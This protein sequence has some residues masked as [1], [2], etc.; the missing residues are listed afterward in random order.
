MKPALLPPPMERRAFTLVELLL[1]IGLLGVASSVSVPLY[2]TYQARN[3]LNTA[4]EQTIQ[5]LARAKLLSQSA[6][7]DSSWGFFVPAGILYK[8]ESYKARDVVVDEVYPMPSTV[9]VSG[10]ILEVAYSKLDGRPSATGSIILTAVDGEQRTIIITVAVETEGVATNA[11]DTIAVCC[12]GPE[13]KTIV[14]SAWP[15]YESQGCTLGACPIPS[16]SSASSAVSSAQASSAAVSSQASSGTSASSVS[17]GGGGGGSSSSLPPGYFLI[18]HKP[19][20]YAEQTMTVNQSAWNNGHRKH[21]DTIGACVSTP[22]VD[23]CPVR[24]LIQE[25]GTVL[26]TASLSVVA[27]ALASEI[28]YGTGGPSINVTVTFTKKKNKSWSSLFDGD[29]IEAG[30]TDT[31]S[32]VGVSSQVALK[33]RGYFKKSGWLTFDETAV[34]NDGSDHT[35]LLRRGDPL[36]QYLPYGEQALL[37]EI[38]G[39]YLDANGRLTIAPHM[40]VVLAELSTITYP[41]SSSQDFQDAVLLLEFNG[42]PSC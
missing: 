18:C 17:S 37:E 27:R 42:G 7:R 10:S 16:S 14:D 40:L 24:F 20:T 34:T 33:I 32:N 15:S 19:G 6:E 35:L 2:R 39:D 28:T 21:G 23:T 25:D 36:P 29:P 31:V 26:T 1:V 8:G 38:L 30:M 11:G 9:T 13:T 3:D 41:P 22:P 4:T 12:P 5:G